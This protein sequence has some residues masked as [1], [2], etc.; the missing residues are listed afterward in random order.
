[1]L[2]EVG[3]IAKMDTLYS[4]AILIQLSNRREIPTTSK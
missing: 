2:I 4:Q 3:M 1:M